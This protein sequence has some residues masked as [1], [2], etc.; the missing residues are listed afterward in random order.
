[1]KTKTQNSPKWQILIRKKEKNKNRIIYTKVS[2]C[3]DPEEAWSTVFSR[4]LEKHRDLIIVRLGMRGLVVKD[5]DGKEFELLVDYKR[6]D[7]VR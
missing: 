2:N 7:P 4:W 5:F 3:P 1:M 6:I